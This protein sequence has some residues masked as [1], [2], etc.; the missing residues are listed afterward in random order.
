MTL[1]RLLY[2]VA[3]AL[4]LIAS[5]AGFNV[6]VHSAHVLAFVASGLLAATLAKAV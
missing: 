4:F 6:L 5:L 1:N 2:I 3:A